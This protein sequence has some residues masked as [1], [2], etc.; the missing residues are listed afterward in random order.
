MKEVNLQRENI[1]A[2]RIYT[3]LVSVLKHEDLMHAYSNTRISLY[4]IEKM[5][6]GFS[7]L[8]YKYSIL[9]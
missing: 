8:P 9:S 6:S 3:F 7:E 2:F 1:S 5:V 4:L